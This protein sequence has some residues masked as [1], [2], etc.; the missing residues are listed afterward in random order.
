[1]ETTE[2]KVPLSTVLKFGD[3]QG[4][5]QDGTF[6]QITA[7]SNKVGLHCASLDQKF[8]QAVME[9]QQAQAEKNKDALPATKQEEKSEE[10]SGDEI[11]SVLMISQINMPE[12]MAEFERII[13]SGQSCLING[14]IKMTKTLWEDVSYRD[15]K[16][17]LG[18]YM[19]NFIIVSDG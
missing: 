2:A 13:L 3:A 5:Q 4:Q 10:V 18:E 19:A 17:I 14:E 9:L 7:P 6:V 15:A 16:K 12:Y 1:M 8:Q 11:L